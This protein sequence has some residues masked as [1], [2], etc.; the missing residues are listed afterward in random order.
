VV[1]GGVARDHIVDV[2]LSCKE[3][4]RKLV[5]PYLTGG[6][7]EE[8]IGIVEVI[9]ASGAD[10][11]EIGIPFSDPMIDGTTI[12]KASTD[13][14]QRGVTPGAIFEAI[15]EADI[16]IPVIVMTYYNI[17]FRY[18]HRRFAH[19]LRESGVSGVILPDLPLE[20]F[21]PWSREADDVGL[22]TILLVAPSTGEERRKMISARSRGFVY[23]VGRMGTT[24]EQESLADSAR[25]V[26]LDVKAITELP[27][28]IGVGISNA[29]QA[30]AIS[31]VADGVIVGSAVVRRVLDGVGLEEIASFVQGLRVAVDS[32]NPL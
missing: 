24:G 9:A 23:G 7:C 17:V 11:V 8:W 32:V 25:R 2:C 15:A 19:E 28:L 10:A 14:L 31:A 13:A 30:R 29:D 5:I 16:S 21:E 22:A 4:G 6:M 1:V 18:G 27:V 3:Q 20:E 12:Q 26:A